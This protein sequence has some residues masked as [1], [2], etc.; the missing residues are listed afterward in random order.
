MAKRLLIDRERGTFYSNPVDKGHGKSG[1]I[2]IGVS[3]WCGKTIKVKDASGQEFQVNKGSLID[4]LKTIPEGKSLKKGFLCLNRS[5][6][7][8][9]KAVFKNFVTRVSPDRSKLTS[10]NTRYVRFINK[11][12]EKMKSEFKDITEVSSATCFVEI[13]KDGKS[14]IHQYIFASED[15]LPI[16]NFTH[17]LDDIG[18]NLNA[19]VPFV[20]SIS[21]Q[22]LIISKLPNGDFYVTDGDGNFAS[23]QSNGGFQETEGGGGS[24][25]GSRNKQGLKLALFRFKEMG[26]EHQQIFADNKFVRGP[27]FQ[28][29]N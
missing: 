12:T 19:E 28:D 20:G 9:V 3:T 22:W 16:N 18:K 6:D 1:H 24:S 21:Q 29:L 27:Y 8:K 15:N 25:G 2:K 23:R 10:E 5:N 17:R 26:I 7:K 14:N 4:F 13:T 11:M